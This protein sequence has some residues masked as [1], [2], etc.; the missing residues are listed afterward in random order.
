MRTTSKAAC[1]LVV[2]ALVV[3]GCGGGDSGSAEDE[4]AIEE[5]VTLMRRVKRPTGKS[6]VSEDQF[7]RSAWETAR[8]CAVRGRCPRGSRTQARTRR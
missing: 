7:A 4:A 3:S 8:N 1:A 6:Y 5:V 2:G